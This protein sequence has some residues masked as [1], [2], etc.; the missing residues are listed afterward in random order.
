[1]NKTAIYCITNLDKTAIDRFRHV[2]ETDD[3]FEEVSLLEK[4]DIAAWNAEKL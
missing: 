4:W 2:I 1:M 3:D